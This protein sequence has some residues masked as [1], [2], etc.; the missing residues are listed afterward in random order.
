S[1]SRYLARIRE[2][3]RRSRA[4]KRE[5]MQDLEGKIRS[6]QDEGL[7]L[8]IEIQ[9]T[10]RRVLN[11]NRRLRELLN[12]VGV[13]NITIDEYL[14]I[15][16]QQNSKEDVISPEEW[17]ELEDKILG[18][19]HPCNTCVSA[20]LKT[21]K[22][23]SSIRQEPLSNVVTSIPLEQQTT[24][25]GPQ[26]QIDLPSSTSISTSNNYNYS[27]HASLLALDAAYTQYAPPTTYSQHITSYIPV[28]FT[29]Y[30]QS[31]TIDS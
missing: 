24:Y 17:P 7:Q 4:R 1:E 19:V 29:A 6:C 16:G 13:D 25:Q 12:K 27:S 15:L 8:N 26:Q 14:K 30:F 11:E 28:D 22:L 10:A 9:K 31:G 2:N 18:V 21:D 5:Y 3:Q 23:N 20:T